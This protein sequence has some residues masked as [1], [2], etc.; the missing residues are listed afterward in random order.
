MSDFLPTF[1]YNVGGW[2][3]KWW[4]LRLHDKSKAPYTGYPQNLQSP[5]PSNFNDVN[6]VISF[7][8]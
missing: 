5:L 1:A 3:Q 4:I 6:F 8:I 2:V 7:F